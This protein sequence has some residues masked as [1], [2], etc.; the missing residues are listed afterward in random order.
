[1]QN[2]TRLEMQTTEKTEKK[3]L[4][5]HQG[6]LGDFIVT[7]PVL[8][9]LRTGFVR[10]DG[11]CRTEFG[12]LAK[13]LAVIDEFYPQDAARFAGLYSVE[14]NPQVAEL[15]NAYD[16]IL[17]FSFSEALEE[18][19]RRFKMGAVHRIPPWPREEESIQVTEFLFQRLKESKLLPLIAATTTGMPV[20]HLSVDD[21]SGGKPGPG[22]RVILCPG[23]GNGPKRW[24][25]EGYLQVADM[26]IKNG[27]RPEWVLGPAERDLDSALCARPEASM[28]VHHSLGLV[29]LAELLRSAGGYVGNDSA[30]S[31]LAAF[32]GVPSVVVFGPSNPERWR[33]TG[34]RVTILKG[35]APCRLQLNE[36]KTGCI[37]SDCMKQVPP[38]MVLKSFLHLVER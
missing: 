2:P 36:A 17:L 13:H 16:H 34:P 6:A 25:L 20:R 38:E 8:R 35:A 3:L 37:D 33:P 21:G 23:A 15:L 1:M 19:V 28:P 5:V 30:V 26:F 7:F 31:H 11:I 18:S 22:S 27:F 12:R 9:A 10:I 4:F 24:P 14:T 29:Q 32:L